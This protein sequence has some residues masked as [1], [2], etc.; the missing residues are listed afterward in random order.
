MKS[1]YDLG[2][3]SWASEG[4]LKANESIDWARMHEIDQEVYLGVLIR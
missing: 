3:E 2:L 1:C 4:F